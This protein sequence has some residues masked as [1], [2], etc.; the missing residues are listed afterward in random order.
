MQ[1]ATG[2]NVCFPNIHNILMKVTATGAGVM[3]GWVKH[4]PD[5]QVI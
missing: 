2:S 4:L 3:A 1:F 5:E